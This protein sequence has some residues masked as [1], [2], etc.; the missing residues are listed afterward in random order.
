MSPMRLLRRSRS[1]RLRSRPARCRVRDPRC[2]GR[3]AGGHSSRWAK[4]RQ[5]DAGGRR[6]RPGPLGALEYAARC[7]SASRVARHL[8]RDVVEVGAALDKMGVEGE[9]IQVPSSRWIRHATRRTF[10]RPISRPST[11]RPRASPA[12]ARGRTPCQGFRHCAPRVPANADDYTMDHTAAVFW[13]TRTSGRQRR[14]ARRRRMCWCAPEG[15][16]LGEVK[17]L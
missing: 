16:R 5:R 2:T 3:D 15:D 14:L 13:S 4:R 1:T 7:S 12:R 9:K 17:R 8:S 10:S 11:A 6:R